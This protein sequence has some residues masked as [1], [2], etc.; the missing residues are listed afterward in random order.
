MAV[1]VYSSLLLVTKNSHTYITLLH[2]LLREDLVHG[3]PIRLLSN[4]PVLESARCNLKKLQ[5]L[6]ILVAVA[7]LPTQ[8]VPSPTIW[9][10]PALNH[11]ISPPSTMPH[12][13]PKNLHPGQLFLKVPNPFP[14]P[15]PSLPLPYPFLTNPH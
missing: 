10:K 15:T 6:K 11:Q 12:A 8:L 4:K 3:N 13:Q 1:T 7:Q 5:L 9:T 14:N 2:F